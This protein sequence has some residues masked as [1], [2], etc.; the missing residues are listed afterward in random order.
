[1]IYL[2]A[3]VYKSKYIKTKRIRVRKLIAY[4]VFSNENMEIRDIKDDDFVKALKRGVK[5][6]NAKLEDGKVVVPEGSLNL[7]PAIVDD[8]LE[9]L[10]RYV[11]VPMDVVQGT[12][13]LVQWNGEYK[14]INEDALA[15][16][17]FSYILN[18]QCYKPTSIA[19][20]IKKEIIDFYTKAGCTD[21]ELT[22]TLK[23]IG[24]TIPDNFDLVIHPGLTAVKAS[25]IRTSTGRLNSVRL[26]N[27]RDRIL[28]LCCTLYNTNSSNNCLEIGKIIITSLYDFFGMQ[29]IEAKRTIDVVVDIDLNGYDYSVLSFTHYRE[30]TLGDLI[31]NGTI[32]IIID[33]DKK[34]KY[35]P[36][37]LG[38]ERKFLTSAYELGTSIYGY[39]SLI[40]RVRFE[41]YSLSQLNA[42]NFVDKISDLITEELYNQLMGFIN[43]CKVDIDYVY[44]KCKARFIKYNCV[45]FDKKTYYIQCTNLYAID[46]EANERKTMFIE[47]NSCE[48]VYDT[49]NN[50]SNRTHYLHKLS[51]DGLGMPV[52][53]GVNLSYKDVPTYC[54]IKTRSEPK[55]LR[56][57]FSSLENM[58]VITLISLLEKGVSFEQCLF[59]VIGNYL[60]IKSLTDICIFDYALIKE[61]LER[62]KS[63]AL[64]RLERASNIVGAYDFNITA[65]GVLVSINKLDGEIKIPSAVK[66]LSKGVFKND[67][68]S[69]IDIPANMKPINLK[70]FDRSR[71]RISK[72]IVRDS[73]NA[74][75]ALN[76]IKSSYKEDAKLIIEHI[77]YIVADQKDLYKFLVR[78]WDTNNILCLKKFNFSDTLNSEYTKKFIG[79]I[80]T[81]S[82]YLELVRLKQRMKEINTFES[83]KEFFVARTMYSDKIISL[84]N[85]LD[86]GFMEKALSS[87]EYELFVSMIDKHILEE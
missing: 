57:A 60:V 44:D 22:D 56:K 16:R 62:K 53:V 49:I 47:S 35:T 28:N 2:I 84:L 42:K 46:K 55:S 11:L 68:Y 29:K 85:C 37:Q 67:C 31:K 43:L 59:K 38:H 66:E 61:D 15:K 19:S 79:Y 48:K 3:T 4:R 83:C 65:L 74:C 41:D 32:R 25:A 73:A 80:I 72:L 10:H 14:I 71:T 63:E 50:V 87:E 76:M 7:Y 26:N 86:Y 5:V 34:L 24:M 13:A 58:D 18:T 23:L 6:E 54:V 69:V 70:H 17:D 21:I 51:E 82:G 8:G 9:N 12:Y 40:S 52:L 39:H 27:T 20:S 33:S 64:K 81:K 77:N 36:V 75:A 45:V 1:M 30:T 78:V